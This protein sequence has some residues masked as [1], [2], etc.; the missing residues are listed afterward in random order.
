MTPVEILTLIFISLAVI[1]LIVVIASPKS[2]AKVI[3]G[4]W[5]N[6]KVVAVISF[7]LALIVLYYLLQEMTIVQVFGAMVFTALLAAMGISVYSKEIV[8]MAQKI[9]KN[10][11]IFV[12]KRMWLYVLIWIALI[13]WALIVLFA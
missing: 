2:W 10:R 7:I 3:K 4:C 9:L 11:N 12:M 5:K 6:P 1:K 13:V 8:T